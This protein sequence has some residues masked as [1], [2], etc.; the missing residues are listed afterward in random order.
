M[1]S[2]VLCCIRQRPLGDRGADK[3]KDKGGG[4][5][6]RHNKNKEKGKEEKNWTKEEVETQEE[7]Q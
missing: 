3:D 7:A 5:N 2:L 1:C 6:H 4:S